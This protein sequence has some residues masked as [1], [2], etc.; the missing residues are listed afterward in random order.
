MNT[1][2]RMHAVPSPII[3]TMRAL[4]AQTPDTISLAQGAVAYGPPQA[5]LDAGL[6]AMSES[7]VQSYGNG[8]GLPELHERLRTKLRDE[9][10]I[11]VANGSRLIVT[12]GA[13]MAFMHAVFAILDPGDDVIL[14]TPFYFNHDMAVVM[15]SGRVIPVA[16]DAENHPRLDAIRAAITPRTRAIVTVS[17]NN[18][19]G[20]VYSEADLRAINELCRERGMYHISDEAYEYFTYDSA[21][22]F[23][24]GACPNAAAHTISI[25][26]MSKTYGMAGW[27]VGYM[28]YPAHLADAIAKIQDTIVVCPAILPQIVAA[29]ALEVGRAYCAPH[30]DALADTRAKISHAL[31]PL[32]PHCTL[33]PMSGSFF[34]WLK[35]DTPLDS[36]TL[37]TRLIREHRVAVIPGA[38]F[39]THD[40]CYLRIA[41]GALPPDIV[42][43]GIA[44]LVD[45]LQNLTE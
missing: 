17:P 29:R 3:P 45:S 11:D 38:A 19:T 32:A 4:A 40:G 10:G 2:A 21:T 6:R 36:L 25:F 35:I 31:Q 24:P 7:R 27:R 22:H 39:G 15:A 9:N 37:A 43:E 14:L 23:S 20:A 18:P 42:L 1:T 30:V 33:A 41:Y 28:V 44:R 26:S 16:T 13:N 5:A 34:A 8:A 12:A